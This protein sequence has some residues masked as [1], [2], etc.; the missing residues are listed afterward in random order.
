M[1]VTTDRAAETT[2]VRPFHV[3][4]AQADLDDLRRRI[5]ATRWPE[6]ETVAVE[7]QGVQLATMTTEVRAAFRSLRASRAAQ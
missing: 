3:E 2:A 6:K 7:P 5:A 1:A 4:V